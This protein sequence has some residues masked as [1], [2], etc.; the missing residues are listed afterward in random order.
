[1]ERGG[2]GRQVIAHL[3]QL[4]V[5]VC[6]SVGP[7]PLLSPTLHLFPTSSGTAA[8]SPENCFWFPVFSVFSSPGSGRRQC[9]WPHQHGESLLSDRHR[10]FL[11]LV[12]PPGPAA[13]PRTGNG[14]CFLGS[15]PTSET[16]AL[17]AVA[18][19]PPRAV[20]GTPLHVPTRSFTFQPVG[21]NSS[22]LL[23]FVS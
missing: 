22:R 17:G 10:A 21:E 23:P 18:L 15:R 9:T 5:P 19:L 7:S 20:R 13:L 8:F 14:S 4:H 3:R 1:M 11:G 2:T 12:P 16:G 6:P